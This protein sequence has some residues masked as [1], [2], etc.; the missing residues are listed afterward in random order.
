[1]AARKEEFPHDNFVDNMS[2]I[3]YQ[4]MKETLIEYKNSHKLTNQTTKQY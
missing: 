2:D 4:K 1:M 3:G